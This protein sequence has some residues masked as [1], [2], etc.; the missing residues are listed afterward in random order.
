MKLQH[1]SS[2]IITDSGGIQK[3]AYILSRP[4]ITLRNETEW[5]E[6]VVNGWNILLD[7]NDSDFSEKLVNFNPGG[8]FP[9]VFGKNVAGNIVIFP[10]N[11]YDYKCS[12]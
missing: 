8:F 6:T 5:T 2:K 1:L 3:E 4:C 12:F 7:H 11:S 9:P 10:K